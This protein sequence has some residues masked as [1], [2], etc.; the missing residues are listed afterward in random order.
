MVG[1]RGLPAS[2]GGVE[3]AVE[4]LSARLTARGHHVTVF[5]RPKYCRG[6]PTRHRG[7]DLRYLPAIPTKHLEA[8]SHTFLSALAA[9]AGRYD[10][11]H[12]HSIGPALFAWI[13]R[14][15]GRRVVV[16]VHALDWRR[17]KWGP[18][19]RAVLRLGARAAACLPHATIGVSAA[20]CG[21]FQEMYHRAPHHIPNGVVLPTNADARGAASRVTKS[22]E[23]PYLLFLGRLVPEKKVDDL[24]A[25]FREMS[26]ALR[27]VVAGDGAFSD[28]YVASLRRLATVDPRITFTGGVYGDA[29]EALLRE[30]AALINPSD[31]EGHPIVVLEALAHGVPVL[32]SDIGEHREILEGEDAGGETG[33]LFRA[34]DRSDLRRG[35][36]RVLRLPRDSV[37]REGRRSLVRARYDWERI[38]EATESVYAAVVGSATSLTPRGT[39]IAGTAA[40]PEGER[41]C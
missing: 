10:V 20:L 7:V 21:H 37:S 4:E 35:L 8:A 2:H 13:P 24:I 39:S 17:R 25:A 30:A 9:A 32:L 6:R 23:A 26:G 15:A 33:V 40:R 38:A 1:C 14:L 18:V 5:C 3:R 31:L 36:E 22:G 12:V 19:A 34:G 28:A 29:K 11:V 41:S 16:T 27:L